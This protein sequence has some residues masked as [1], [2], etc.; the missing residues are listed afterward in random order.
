LTPGKELNWK[1]MGKDS[2]LK[3]DLPIRSEVLF[4]KLEDERIAEL[5][6]RYSGSQKEREVRDAAVEK[7]VGDKPSKVDEPKP[8]PVKSPEEI[9]AAF[10]ATLDLRVAKIVKIERHP[11]ADKLYIETLE[12][13]DEERIIVSGLVPFYREDE[14]L[15]KHIIVAYNLKAA[16]LRGVESR[17]M[18]LAASDQG[19]IGP[20]GQPIERCEVLDAGDTPTGTK[21]ELAGLPSGELPAEIDID[22]FFSIP[23]LVRNNSVEAGGRALTLR[24]NPILTKVISNGDVH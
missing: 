17:G 7:A 8:A 20:E 22:T 15:G 23:L 14:L 24:G 19:G 11:K 10:A 12:I 21:V 1:D 6:D 2:G 18:L 4:A 9:A 16:K 13:G 3:P 5:R